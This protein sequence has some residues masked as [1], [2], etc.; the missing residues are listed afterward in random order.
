MDISNKFLAFLVISAIFLSG[1]SSFALINKLNQFASGPE[2]I[3]GLAS[4]DAGQ[5]NLTVE[6]T[7]SIIL[8]GSSIIDFGSGYVN[9][10][11]SNCVWSDWGNSYHANL[12]VEY[13]SYND[14]DNCWVSQSGT[15]NQPTNP[16]R[17][18]NDGNQNVTLEVE[19]PHPDAFFAGLGGS[20]LRNI[21]WRA[22]A[23]ESNACGG[24][25]PTTWT[26]SSGSTQQICGGANKFRYNPEGPAGNGDEIAVDVRVIVPAGLTPQEYKND[27]ITFTASS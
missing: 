14:E 16:F 10:S 21:S 18:E 20:N 27:S 3:V 26:F 12:T 19:F 25:L 17:V 2:P 23:N 6:S 4:S 8:R 11:D 5:I 22:R 7:L 13:Q 9:E 24:S 15:P 1:I